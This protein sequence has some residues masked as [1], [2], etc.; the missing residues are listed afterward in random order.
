MG[1]MIR[2]L[3]KFFVYVFLVIPIVRA[4]VGFIV[5]WT[6]LAWILGIVAAIGVSVWLESTGTSNKILASIFDPNKS[7]GDAMGESMSDLFSGGDKKS[8][9]KPVET[10]MTCPSCGKQVTLHDGRGKCGACDTSY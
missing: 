5:P 7:A 10:T 3:I 9:H 8:A 2:F 4:I 1:S 6:W